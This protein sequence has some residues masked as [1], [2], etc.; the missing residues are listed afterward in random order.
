MQCYE[1]KAHAA[2]MYKLLVSV[3][4]LKTLEAEYVGVSAPALSFPS[5]DTSISSTYRI[6]YYTASAKCTYECGVHG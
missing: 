3:H 1:R 6:P 4:I 2:T 5:I